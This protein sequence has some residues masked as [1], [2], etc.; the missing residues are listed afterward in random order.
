MKKILFLMLLGIS[1]VM[2][3]AE[4][5]VI[6]ISNA[7]GDCYNRDVYKGIIAFG[8]M[9]AVSLDS[10]KMAFNYMEKHCPR[11]YDEA[12]RVTN[13]YR[14]EI[15]VPMLYMATSMLL[16]RISDNM[17]KKSNDFSKAANIILRKLDQ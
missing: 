10:V 16:R 9:T 11:E 14:E 7:M 15:I 3:D 13:K 6:D 17:I 4:D 8:T 1:S 5:D 12:N 2:A